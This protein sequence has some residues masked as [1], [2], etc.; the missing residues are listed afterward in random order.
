MHNLG[1]TKAFQ[2]VRSREKSV[3]IGPKGSGK[4]AIL[5]AVSSASGAGYSIVVTPEVFATSMLRKFVEDSAGMWDEDEAFVSTWIF[6]LL[7]EVFKRICER[8]RGIPAQA[9]HSVRDFLREHATY[10]EVDIFTR[11]IKYLKEI[12]NVKT[13]DIELSSKTKMLQ[14]L[15]AL[16][17]LYAQVPALRDGL[18][19]DILILIDELDQG[20][21]NSLHANRFIAALL[22]AAIRIQRLGLRVHVVVFIRSEI[23]D[24][25][26]YQLEQLDKLRSSIEML[27]WTLGDLAGLILKRVDYC[28][29]MG[30]KDI[31]AE[32]G[33]I[34]TLFEGPCN[35][36]PGFEYL[37][38]R[39][40]MRP[41]E[42]L[43]I[44]RRAHEIA[45]EE[46]AETITGQAIR[47]A[48]E[49]FSNWKL[50]HLCTEY[51]FIFPGLE[52]FLPKFRGIGPV[53]TQ[54][55]LATIIRD[56]VATQ[57]VERLPHWLHESPS[58]IIQTLYSI[59]FVGVSRAT[60][61]PRKGGGMLS[62]YEF[63]YERPSA[64]VSGA[65]SF[66]VHPALWCRLE[67][68]TS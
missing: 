13:G 25:V 5:K 20:W 47:K 58:Q 48:E 29:Q 17:P 23:W 56:Y 3:V 10:Q 68:E 60:P 45:V 40:T 59:E 55:D 14:D 33:L 67:L 6:T 15:Y 37:A 52:R 44:V 49:D 22:Q 18:K 51:K 21:D 11:F 39:T 1:T 2:R 12:Q 34:S 16:E 57:E 63:A 19:E 8:A 9:L 36:M 50:E 64:N 7:V 4:S 43:Q 32:Y 66:L 35:G 61:D 53:V 54:M 62:R 27:S 31:E 46:H 41:R 65:T 42:I 26:K 38:S 24:L 30:L 28:L